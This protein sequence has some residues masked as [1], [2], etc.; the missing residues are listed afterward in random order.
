MAE[1]PAKNDKKEA[2]PPPEAGTAE[3]PAKK[4]LPVKMM[5]IMAGVM[6]AEGAVVY[7]IAGAT[8]PKPVAADVKH[9]EEEHHDE[10]VEIPLIDEKFQNLQSGRAYI[11]DAS[12][13]LKVRTKDEELV[14]STI[15]KSAAEVKE[16]VALVF[17]RA[18]H[19]QLTEPGL[20]TLNRQLLALLNQFAGKDAEGHPRIVRVLIPKCKGYL[21]E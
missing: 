12:I 6:V 4:G 9:V 7:F 20:E 16:A 11:W 3:K 13:V 5:G 21:A 1:K 14:A 19:A 10:F 15:E 2:A 18:P 8:G 17:R